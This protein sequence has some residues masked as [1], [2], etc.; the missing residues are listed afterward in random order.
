MSARFPRHADS[1]EAAAGFAALEAGIADRFLEA[2]GAGIVEDKYLYTMLG[3]R[4]AAAHFVGVFCLANTVEPLGHRKTEQL[5][6][7]IPLL[8]ADDSM[9]RPALGND[10]AHYFYLKYMAPRGGAKEIRVDQEVYAK[11]FFATLHPP[12]ANLAQKIETFR[13]IPMQER[14]RHLD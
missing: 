4:P 1:A 7:A 3:N 5:R 10:D 9:P 13:I 8:D 2:A 6:L 11:R 14:D 12:V